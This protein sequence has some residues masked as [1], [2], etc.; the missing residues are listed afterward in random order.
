M[1][2]QLFKYCGYIVFILLFSCEAKAFQEGDKWEGIFDLSRGAQKAV[3]QFDFD[4]KSGLLVLPDLIPVPLTL[5]EVSQKSDSVFFTIGFRS[6]PGVCKAQ[7]KGD[8]IK[9]IMY[10]QQSGDTQFWLAK[11]GKVQSIFNQPKPA[12]DEP[13]VITTHNNT[14][15]EN[16]V[17]QRLETLL[18]KYDLEKY[19]YTKTIKIQTGIIPHSHP[20]LTLNTDIRNETDLLAT[21]LH[22]QMHWYSLSKQYDSD[23]L[24]AEIF[25]RYPKVPSALPEGAGDEQST[26]LHLVVCYLE[27]HTLSQVIGREKA[28]EHME[29]MTTQNYRWVYR[30]LLKDMDSLEPL[31][32]SVGLHFD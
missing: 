17:K 4:A 19:I 3:A 32:A 9:G 28:M 10:N 20:V 30:T 21:F 11:A 15:E 22:E 8:S 2:Q 25:K 18:E 31:M 27:F 23:A 6:G 12:A 7:I 13:I 16:I 26:Y 29:F 5:T 1:H 14:Q 24:A